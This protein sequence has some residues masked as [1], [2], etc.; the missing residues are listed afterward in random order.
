MS[1]AVTNLVFLAVSSVLAVTTLLAFGSASAATLKEQRAMFLR[2][3][4]ELQAG[5]IESFQD[6]AGKLHDYPLYPYLRFEYLS[7]YLWKAKDAQ[8]AAFL[9]QYPDLPVAADLRRSWLYYLAKRNHWQTYVDNYTTQNDEL[10]QCYYLHARLKAGRRAYLLEDIRTVWLTGGSRPPQCDEAFALL[11]KSDLMMD[12]LLW[13]R[14][15]L[16]MNDGSTRLAAYLGRKL[17]HTDRAWVDRWIAMHNNPWKWTADPA[18]GDA[19]QAREILAYGIRRLASRDVGKAIERWQQLRGRYSFDTDQVS[20][21]ETRLAVMAARNDQEDATA[22]LDAIRPQQVDENIFQ[23]RIATALKNR[24]W[25][26]L[27]KWTAG[28]ATDPSLRQRRQYWHARALEETGAVEQARA[29]YQKLV[30]ERDYY[31][32]AASDRLGI[33]YDMHHQ[34]VPEDDAAMQELTAMPGMVRAHELL[35]LNMDYYARR[36]WYGATA[37]LSR[38]QLQ[39][40]AELASQWGW[41]DRAILTLGKAEAYDDLTL[42]FPTPFDRVIS[43][44]AKRFKLDLAWMYA[45]IRAESAFMEDARSPSGAMGLM[46]V[47]PETGRETARAMGWK[48]FH[49]RD[50]NHYE[51]NI[52]I[53]TT[54]LRKMYDRFGN[55]LILATAAYNAGPQNVTAWLPRKGCVEPDIWIEQIPYTETRKYVSR[56]LYYASIYDWRLQHEIKPV[57]MRMSYIAAKSGRKIADLSCTSAALSM[58]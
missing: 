42:R 3:K 20:G 40:A 7:R 26:M 10:L 56:I 13:Q 37:D 8:L 27:L 22:L 55:N 29:I 4:K 57:S 43:R 24:D 35:Q 28:E 23:W 44:Y 46:Q 49:S 1:R 52:H 33:P 38:H 5:H 15:R 31:G 12:E 17:R 21:I 53:G 2:A 9:K 41:Y 39:I 30:G 32:F 47:M 25:H 54:Y 48:S 6:I 19:P 36:E 45:L 50:L 11:Y 14:I 51:K 58:R 18:F 34:R 16:A